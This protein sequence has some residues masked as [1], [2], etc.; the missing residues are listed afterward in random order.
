M[1]GQ[2]GAA[3]MV[4]VD[5]L[6]GL[7]DHEP[8]GFAAKKDETA[9]DKTDDGRFVVVDA[10]EDCRQ[11]ITTIAMASDHSWQLRL[12]PLLG[13]FGTI[14]GYWLDRAKDRLVLIAVNVQGEKQVGVQIVDLASRESRFYPLPTFRGS[15]ALLA[16]R[17]LD[18]GR[19][20]VT[21]TMEG[22]C[23]QFSPDAP[24]ELPSY[25]GGPS[26]KLSL[27][28]ATLPAADRNSAQ[29]EAP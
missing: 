22:A 10:V 11:C 2:D 27:C 25:Q 8:K 18:D 26:H 19:A 21:Y 15:P 5:R 9:L 13:R 29:T 24:Y 7:I 23:D 4:S 14:P 3:Q 17:F 16:A 6:P 20:R 1:R 12:N 28:L